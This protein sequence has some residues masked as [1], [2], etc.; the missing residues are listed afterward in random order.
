V[1]SDGGFVLV[2]GVLMETLGEHWAV[3]SPASGESHLVNDSSAAI[4]E[5]LTGTLALNADHICALL[6]A[7]ID[8]TLSEVEPLVNE[9]LR[10]FVT[11]GLVRMVP[12]Q[13][14]IAA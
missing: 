4:L 12:S 11:A 9:A 3:F 2:A 10:T 14:N 5:M 13:G 6:A 8:S 7:D 1:S